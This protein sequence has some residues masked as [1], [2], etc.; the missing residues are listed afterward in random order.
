M[1]LCLNQIILPLAEFALEVDVVI[2][3]Q[4]TALCGPSGSGKTSLLDLIAG[5]RHPK[6]A[7]IQLDDWILTDTGKGTH[8]PTRHRKIG[9]VPQDLA[10]FPH[11]HIPGVRA[12]FTRVSRPFTVRMEPPPDRLA[13]VVGY[14][15]RPQFRRRYESFQTCLLSPST[16]TMTSRPL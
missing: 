16:T 2:E 3:S 15:E 13:P 9:Y 7:F 14:E 10:L 1:K 4:V 12:G 6:T 5:L 8:V 11:P